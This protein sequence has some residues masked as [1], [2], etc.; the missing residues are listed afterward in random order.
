MIAD[1][2]QKSRPLGIR[3]VGGEVTPLESGD[4]TAHGAYWF[5][6]RA[7]RPWAARTKRLIDLWGSLI[8]IILLAPVFITIMVLIKLTSPG[9]V[10]FR[11]RR[12]GFRCNEFD[13]YKFRTM[14]VD[15]EKMQAELDGHQKP[16]FKMTDDPRITPIGRYLRRFSLD[17]LPQLFNVVEGTM[18]LVGPRPLLISDLKKFPLRGQMRRFSVKPGITGLWQVS[19]RSSTSDEDRL[20]LDREYVNHW[21]LWLDTKILFRTVGAVLSGRGAT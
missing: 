19:G 21:S 12:I 1:E 14:V 5:D 11:Q 4:E 2:K 7:R 16:F 9:P 18:S 13:M 20:R 17:E 6:L 10:A 8:L 3:T 15:A